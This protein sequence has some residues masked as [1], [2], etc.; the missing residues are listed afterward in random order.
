VPTRKP[1]LIAV[2]GGIVRASTGRAATLPVLGRGTP[3]PEIARLHRS[4]LAGVLVVANAELATFAFHREQH[5]LADSDLSKQMSALESAGYVA[6]TERGR[7]PGSVT[8]YQATRAG[9]RAGTR[10][11]RRHRAALYAMLGDELREPDDAA[12]DGQG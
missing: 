9:T 3:P 5:G 1:L 11:Y 10:A 6:V 8:N 12:P 2:L 7:G 4:Y